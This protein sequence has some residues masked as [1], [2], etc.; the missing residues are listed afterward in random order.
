MKSGGEHCVCAWFLLASFRWHP[1]HSVSAQARVTT[2]FLKME[3]VKF[4]A[5]SR[6]RGC[7]GPGIHALQTLHGHVV[8]GGGRFSGVSK[9]LLVCH[10][11]DSAWHCRFRHGGRSHCG[12]HSPCS[13]V[14]RTARRI[15]SL[16]SL[17]SLD[18]LEVLN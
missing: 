17:E 10:V 2:T 1:L 16:E 15:L 13:C 3:L 18:M 11:C 4:S 12:N 5:T 8:R 14:Q 7:L 6:R 9:R